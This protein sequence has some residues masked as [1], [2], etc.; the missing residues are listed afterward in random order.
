MLMLQDFLLAIAIVILPIFT[1]IF[2]GIFGI[3]GGIFLVPL[4]NI[5]LKYYYPELDQSMLIANNTSFACIVFLS[6]TT[7]WQRKNEIDFSRQQILIKILILVP[8]SLL[9]GWFIRFI[10]NHTLNLI[11]GI[12][13]IVLAI[14]YFFERKNTADK[15]M[16]F[17]KLF[18]LILF[19]ISTVASLL[20]MSGAIFLFPLLLKAGYSKS[21]SATTCSLA[22]LIISIAA[23]SWLFIDPIPEIA[24]PYFIGDIFW[25]M[26]IT[27][28]LITPLT[29]KIGININKK[30]DEKTLLKILSLLLL[31]ISALHFIA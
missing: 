5:I 26:I 7:L 14:Y 25:P 24:S 19:P 8:G 27:S 4:T 17:K 1:G 20:G 29:I 15:Q 16:F 6:I 28:I 21:K 22:T 30:Y 11:F 31:T 23:T 3:G 13:I 12:S 9:G 18:P 10:E 2:S